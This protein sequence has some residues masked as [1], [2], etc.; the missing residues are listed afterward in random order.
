LGWFGPSR[1]H[2]A[3]GLSLNRQMGSELQSEVQ[4]RWNL[5]MVG[6]AVAGTRLAALC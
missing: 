5:L 6:R 3:H 1:T 4:D 2:K